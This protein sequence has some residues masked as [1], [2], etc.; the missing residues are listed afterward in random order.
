M[1]IKQ[2]NDENTRTAGN[3]KSWKKIAKN[4]SLQTFLKSSSPLKL[5]GAEWTA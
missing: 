1:V 3:N 5:L 4:M 2:D